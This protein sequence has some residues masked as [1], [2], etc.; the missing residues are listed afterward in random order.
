MRTH[1]G[2]P[3]LDAAL[4]PYRGLR[5]FDLA[6]AMDERAGPVEVPGDVRK[7]SLSD[8]S[9]AAL[10]L[11]VVPRWP[12]R[13]GDYALHAVRAACPDHDRYWM[14]EPDVRINFTSA[15]AFFDIYADAPQDFLA[16]QVGPKAETWNHHRTMARFRSEVHGCFFPL[17]RLRGAALDYLCTRRAALLAE[18][19][20][21]NAAGPWQLWPNDE[22]FV[23]TELFHA[24]FSMADL[25]DFGRR[26]HGIGWGF[27][28]PVHAGATLFDT[29]DDRIYHP[30]ARHIGDFVRRLHKTI[31]EMRNQPAPGG[32]LAQ[33]LDSLSL[34]HDR[35]AGPD[36]RPE[37]QA[38]LD[39]LLA[40]SQED[41][42]RDMVQDQ[43]ARLFPDNAVGI[44]HHAVTVPA[45]AG[46][47]QSLPHDFALGPAIAAP[48]FAPGRATAYAADFKRR[49]LCFVDMPHGEDAL[50]V[51][52]FYHA[53]R[54]A[55]QAVA[56]V[57]FDTLD[58]LYPDMPPEVLRPLVILSIGRCG[59]TLLNRLLAAAGRVAVSEPD[60]FSQA[61][62]LMGQLRVQADRA[63]EVVQADAV[64]V[65]RATVRALAVWAGQPPG[66]LALKLRNQA[67]AAI[68]PIHAALP[69]ADYVFVFRQIAP[70]VRSYVTHFNR[71]PQELVTALRRSV[72]AC[73]AL[74]QA[75]RPPLI[76]WYED[77]AAD[78]LA[79]VQRLCGG[80]TPLSAEVCDAVLR[81][82][83]RDS[84]A[85]TAI[86]RQTRDPH[87][88]AARMRADAV[89]SEFGPLWDRQRPVA[90]I[91]RLGLPY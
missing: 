72:L 29:P 76:L 9:I 27:R 5:G 67:N 83:A 25:N 56:R 28:Y 47:A 10:G 11:P 12:Y 14:V 80:K 87:H 65:L 90:E 55:A 6:V 53:Q 32:G 77:M 1:Q 82:G 74:V 26:V 16:T 15:Q 89:L 91:A 60:V 31:A 68:M 24:G 52:F 38:A 54:Q 13:C 34:A 64:A 18:W 85:G 21:A 33:S 39:V 71:N 69:N 59:S 30:V 4:A 75:G 7:V 22:S 88:D 63:P 49:E 42:L 44:T 36:T 51:P 48:C 78:P 50:E 61:P 45:R 81:V 86:S 43:A 66:A 37:A 73:D 57:P 35:P 70:W 40:A 3:A 19:E 8:E 79:I 62:G 46:F 20:A 58:A 41:G 84:Q 23:A 2:G 17:V